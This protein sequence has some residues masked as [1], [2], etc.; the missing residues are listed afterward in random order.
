MFIKM[1]TTGQHLYGALSELEVSSPSI[2]T[3][4]RN[5]GLELEDDFYASSKSQVCERY[6]RKGV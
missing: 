5:P 3:L 1:T 4:Y 2:E 6:V